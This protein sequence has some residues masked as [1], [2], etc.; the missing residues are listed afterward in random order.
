MNLPTWLTLSFRTQWVLSIALA[1]I[2]IIASLTAG[3][4]YALQI[5]QAEASTLVSVGYIVFMSFIIIIYFVFRSWQTVRKERYANIVPYIHRIHHEIRDLTTFLKEKDPKSNA[6]QAEILQH[7][8]QAKSS[9]V[10]ILDQLVLVF[11]SLTSTKC[12]ACIKL[13]YELGNE[14]YVYTYA[15][16]HASGK[17]NKARDNSRNK[18]NRDLLSHNGTFSRLFD[19]E[20]DVW[21]YISNNLIRDY[22]KGQFTS[23]SFSAY[24]SSAD[25]PKTGWLLPY[26]STITCVIRENASELLPEHRC[27]VVGFLAIDSESRGV[28]EP[29]WDVELL[30]SVADSLFHPLSIIQ[31][32][33][34]ATVHRS[35]PEARYDV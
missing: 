3:W 13:M 10:T 5:F 26:R 4:D 15:R 6:D 16:D 17:A 22:K 12:R 9:V 35:Q 31:T 18:T 11:T 19:E 20:V 1:V 34:P 25:G 29:R 2:G 7:L 8:N 14:P 32:T 23:T 24:R 28:F 30:L 21:Y 33:H 27:N